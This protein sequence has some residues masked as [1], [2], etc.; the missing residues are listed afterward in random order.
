MQ[1]FDPNIPGFVQGDIT[2]VGVVSPPGFPA[3]ALP[4]R[5]IDPSK[6]FNVNVAWEVHGSI[7]PIWLDS[8]AANWR[9]E[10]FAESLGGGPE[11]R[12]G[13]VQKA[14]TDTVAC[15]DSPGEPNCSRWEATVNVAPGTLTEGNPGGAADS[16]SGVYKLMVTV[17]LNSNVPGSHGYDMIG[18]HEGPI[19][20]VENPI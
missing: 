18:F 12:I 13:S 19:I 16:P 11:I 4:N 15:T 7:A 14:K 8:L 5:V 9:V 1:Q 6:P 2:S 17:F 3:P 20:G 10:V